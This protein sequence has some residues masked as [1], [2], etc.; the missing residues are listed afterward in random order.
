MEA[1]G[2]LTS[3]GHAGAW[4]L[5]ELNVGCESS[6]QETGLSVAAD[7]AGLRRLKTP[8][9]DLPGGPVVKNLSSKQGTQVR[10]LVGEL[11]S[12]MVWDS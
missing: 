5:G 1:F 8:G 7:M 4:S 2:D 9:G 12:R 3:T 6:R 11:R 10:S